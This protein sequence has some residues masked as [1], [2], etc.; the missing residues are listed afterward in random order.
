[1]TNPTPYNQ[2]HQLLTDRL[3]HLKELSFG[4]EVKINRVIY[5]ISSTKIKALKDIYGKCLLE[6]DYQELEEDIIIDY[7]DLVPDIIETTISDGTNFVI[8]KQDKIFKTFSLCSNVSYGEIY[9]VSEEEKKHSRIIN[10]R[11]TLFEDIAWSNIYFIKEII[12]HP[13]TLQDILLA[14]RDKLSNDTYNYEAS[15][16]LDINC[17]YINNKYY[18]LNK[19]VADQTDE[20][21]LEIIELLK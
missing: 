21:L 18:D 5:R 9:S 14:M 7:K 13:P 19:N 4:C 12:G 11:N 10:E 1:M 8:N 2:L 17:D 3:P 15:L 20:T 6:K 16:L